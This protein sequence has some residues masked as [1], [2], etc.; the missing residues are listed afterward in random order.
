MTGG[1]SILIPPSLFVSNGRGTFLGVPNPA[2]LGLVVA[3]VGYVV[4]NSIV[5]PR[6][7]CAVSANTGAARR[8]G[9][10]TQRVIA[11]V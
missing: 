2:V 9:M 7:V 11:S 5:H 4:L 8:V 3:L 10:P 1:F 6:R